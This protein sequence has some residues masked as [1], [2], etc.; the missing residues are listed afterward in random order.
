MKR[1]FKTYLKE[2]WNPDLHPEDFIKSHPTLDITNGEI[3]ISLTYDE[4]KKK[5]IGK[6]FD[7]EGNEEQKAFKFSEIKNLKKN[8]WK[9]GKTSY[10]KEPEQ[11]PK[12]ELS[13][14]EPPVDVGQSKKEKNTEIDK[15]ANGVKKEISVANSVDKWIEKND[16]KDKNP[17]I[18]DV[19]DNPDDHFY[20]IRMGKN[21]NKSDVMVVHD[22]DEHNK[23]KKVVGSNDKTF[24]IEA[25]ASEDARTF[26][27]TVKIVQNGKD[28]F[29]FEYVGSVIP[30]S[31]TDHKE[32]IMYNDIMSKGDLGKIITSVIE[33]NAQ[34]LLN[35]F[36]RII[37]LYRNIAEFNNDTAKLSGYE[38]PRDFNYL[39]K[40]FDY[41]VKYAFMDK[42]DTKW[43]ELFQYFKEMNINKELLI[44]IYNKN[45]DTINKDAIIHKDI[46]SLDGITDGLDN[47]SKMLFMFYL[48]NSKLTVATI[49]LGFWDETTI[50]NMSSDDNDDWLENS[51][52]SL[53]EDEKE[54][55][56]SLDKI[57][58]AI[59]SW[60][61]DHKNVAYIEIG[62]DKENDYKGGIY[63]FD[64][65]YD[66]LNLQEKTNGKIK[67]FQDSVYGALCSVMKNPENNSMHLEVKLHMV[68][69]GLQFEDLLNGKFKMKPGDEKNDNTKFFKESV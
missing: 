54:V 60:Y 24:F 51:Y 11:E 39:P 35:T 68:E 46:S 7:D 33:K 1:N 48:V 58:F 4:K 13:I 42:T 16:I 8:G 29:K 26:N 36:T 55:K 66:P 9:E 10:K 67:T 14:D 2:A 52:E 21:T 28:G 49:K 50:S 69:N 5:Y 53:T 6:F 57:A 63:M 25:K 40:I 31:I 64:K 17:N 12:P 18:D 23:N 59:R 30:D 56:T 22:K 38:F 32:R 15:Y 37:D 44:N 41:V 19:V 34:P 61:Y 65:K 45:K 3:N 47:T 27:P 62:P 43:N 20:A